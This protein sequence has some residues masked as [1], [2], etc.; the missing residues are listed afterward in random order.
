MPELPEVETVK[1]GLSPLLVNERITE[2]VV[3]VPKLRKP[4]QA[5]LGLRVRG[6]RINSVGRR[7]KYLLFFCDEEVLVSHL[8]MSGHWRWLRDAASQPLKHDHIDLITKSGILRY[9]DPRRFGSFFWIEGIFDY[10]KTFNHELLGKLGMEPF[11]ENFSAKFFYEALRGVRKK[12][13]DVLLSGWPV[14]GVGNIYANEALFWAGI[15]PHRQALD[16]SLRMC[17]QL[18]LAVLDVLSRAISAGGSSISDFI[19]VNGR[20]GYFQND[21]AVYQRAEKACVKC[22]KKIIKIADS[23]SSFVCVNC[24]V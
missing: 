18:R 13:K 1:R 24:Q 6:Q 23:R 4:I 16:L 19:H 9:H 10:Q 11:D 2:L 7:A 14:V 8:G 3:R 5:D 22:A 20:S 17:D 21:Y 15:H 12:I